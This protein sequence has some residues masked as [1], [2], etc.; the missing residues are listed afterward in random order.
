M[1]LSYP[2][3]RLETSP[4]GLEQ[5]LRDLV[6]HAQQ[7]PASAL[8]AILETGASALRAESASLWMVSD[9]GSRLSSRFSYHRST[10][11]R[12]G[13]GEM[14]ATLAA[15][16]LAKLRDVR[17]DENPGALLSG[18]THPHGAIEAAAWCGDEVV[19]LLRIERS[20]GECTWA[21]RFFVGSLA[22]LASREL[23][24]EASQRAQFAL[25]DRERWIDEMERIGHVGSW[26]WDLR[27]SRI[28]WSP[29]QLRIHGLTEAEAPRTFDEFLQLVHPD[30]RD[31][32]VEECTRL[33]ETGEPFSIGY[34]IVR[35]DGSVRELH[36]RGQMLPDATGEMR[37][38]VGTALDVTERRQTE[39]ALHSLELRFRD[40]FEQYPQSV[41]ILSPDGYTLQV[42]AAFSDLFG[43][44][45]EAVADFNLRTDPQ[46]EP[47]REVMERGFA[48][49]VVALPPL[50]YDGRE[51][52]RGPGKQVAWPRWIAASMFPLRDDHGRV[53]ELVLVH[54]DVTEQKLAEEALQASEESYRTIFDSSN[55]AVFVH[56]LASGAVIDANQ[57]AC[58]MCGVE[59][60]ELKQR[61]LEI[62]GSGPHPFTPE[63]ALERIRGAAAGEPQRFEWMSVRSDG[64][65]FWSE[66]MLQRVT[67]RG[68][69]RLLAVVRDIGERKLAERALRQSEESYRTIFRYASDP[70]WV[71]DLDTGHFLDVN[72][73]ACELYGY[74]VEETKELGVQGISWGEEPYTIERAR[75]F[76]V[77]AVAGEPQRFEWLGRH[78]NGSKVWGEV[79]ARR[80]TINGEERLLVAARDINDRKAAEEELRK[81]NDALEQRVA[82]RTA[83]LAATNEALEE[84]VAEHEAAKEQLLERTRELEGVFEALPDQYMRIGPDLTIL[85][86]RTGEGFCALHSRVGERVAEA[87]SPENRDRFVGALEK[88]LATGERLSLEYQER[89]GDEV[90]DYEARILPLADGT[91]IWLGRDITGRK[92]AERT[93]RDREE[94]FRKLI[95]NTSDIITILN[96]DGTVRY[97]SPALGRMLGY[98]HGELNGR[99]V[100][101]LIHEEDRQPTMEAFGRVV[102][103]P[104]SNQSATY[105]FR[106]ADGSWRVLESVGRTLRETGAADGVVVNSR[107]ATERRQ[108]EEALRFQT[109]LLETQNDAA[110]DGILVAHGGKVLSM[111]GRYAELFRVPDELRPLERCQEMLEWCIAQVADPEGYQE[112]IALLRADPETVMRDE[113]TLVDGRVLDRYSAPLRGPE[114]AFYGRIWVIRDITERMRTEAA[115]RQAKDEAERANRAKSE[116]LSRMSHEL[117]TPMN[118]ILGFAQLLGRAELQPQQSKSVQHILKAGRH[119][120]TLINEV[121]EISRIEAGRQ[122]FSLEPVRYCS[123]ALEAVGLVRPLAAQWGVEVEEVAGSRQAFIMADRQ[124]L[125][126][127]LLNLLSNAIKYNRPGGKVRLVC[128]A[129][130][131]AV[132]RIRV[133][134]TG[135]GIPAEHQHQ[136]FTPFAR[137][138]AEQ[139]EVEGT[140]LGLALSQR[141]CEAMGGTLELVESSAAG[142]VFEITLAVADDPVAA[143]DDDAVAAAI[144]DEAGYH[145]ATLLY[146]EDNLANLSLVETI[147]LSRPAWRTIPALQGQLGVELARQH[148]PDLILLDLHL[149]D[150]P[151]DE[152]LR[153]LRAD[154]RTAHIPVVIVS[155]D[156]TRGSLERLQAAGADAYLTKPLDLDQFLETVDRFLKESR[157]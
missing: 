33:R 28:G 148:I 22:G 127:V 121:L 140:G 53:R 24:R 157:R 102:T 71:H 44:G 84:E 134:D 152:V 151:G 49:E 68:E 67:I 122:N 92:R 81:A 155:A 76:M 94:H 34:R 142:T 5:A 35:P 55:D 103:L 74:T 46:L 96:A 109:T 27:T 130:E 29:E 40:L 21:E 116:F 13:D 56:D 146:V 77:R 149:P 110:I 8:R 3:L 87:A 61:G 26:E 117:R 91:L 113:I 78:K 131:G 132:W 32:V 137:L 69:E 111:N 23:E 156:A 57:A 153:R 47:I 101:D 138:G 90:G 144:S 59:L 17:V 80:V 97:Q 83:E 89:V 43:F 98:A 6:R 100:F 14:A 104:G 106:H 120:L 62:I 150:I 147:L 10:G 141:L 9:D 51:L 75:E 99:N 105:R 1:S 42:N 73:A 70:M 41:Q 93:L 154:P 112:K 86:C 135:R 4:E 108:A 118:S 136:L 143:L 16:R 58:A 50:A 72:E 79:R 66:V 37:R 123:V 11:H 19:G 2:D 139:T 48:G 20:V 107:D 85:D 82:E 114:A 45:I 31:W 39:A 38:M 52:G 36:A 12:T 7:D 126:Q 124:R 60:E 129:Q 15:E 133:E 65:E 88:A 95:E 18:G 145:P 119:L 54:R 115:L 25:R 128:G 64:A 30:D 125:V 63:K